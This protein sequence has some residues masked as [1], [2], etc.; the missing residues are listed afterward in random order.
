MAEVL[1]DRMPS[2]ARAR[3]ARLTAREQ[4]ILDLIRRVSFPTVR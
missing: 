2:E 3:Q 1:T 4:E